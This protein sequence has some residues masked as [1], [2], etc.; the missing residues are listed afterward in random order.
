MHL[1]LLGDMANKKVK[2]KR[3][4]AGVAVLVNF[5]FKKESTCSNLI[6]PSTTAGKS[7]QQ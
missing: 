5:D 6:S 1:F 3:I 4:T 7:D 2:F